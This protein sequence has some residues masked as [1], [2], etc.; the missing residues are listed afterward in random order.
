MKRRQ[1][2]K[3]ALQKS[4]E[5]Y[6]MAMQGGSRKLNRRLRA[7]IRVLGWKR[8]VPAEKWVAHRLGTINRASAKD[9]GPA[10]HTEALKAMAELCE[11]YTQRLGGVPTSK[12][13]AKVS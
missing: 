4:A 9:S 2:K 1:I 3:F 6:R 11:F 10:A 7:F 8:D 5:P 12:K 13:V